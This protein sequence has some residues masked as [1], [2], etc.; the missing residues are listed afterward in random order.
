[1]KLTK[2]KKDII[3]CLILIAITCIIF[4][5]FLQGHYIADTY[6]IIERGLLDYSIGNSFT[7]GRMIMGLLNL[8]IDSL[9]IPMM[10]YV[11]G[12]LFF[13]IILS[14]ITIMVLK[15]TILKFRPA[16]NMWLEILV[17]VI[18]YVTIFNFMYIENLY[19]IECIVMALSLL[20]YTIGANLLVE[21]NKGYLWKSAVCVTVGMLAY[22]GTIGFFLALVFL[23]SAIKNENKISKIIKD[24]LLSVALF[25]L[26]GLIDIVAIKIFTSQLNTEQT[27]LSNSIW[28]NIL[29][30]ITNI[31]KTLTECCGMFPKDSL[32]MFLSI[33]VILAV[34]G[35]VEKYKKDSGKGIIVWFLLVAFVIASGFASSALSTSA[36]WAPRMRFCI[37]ALVGIL[38]L[39]LYVSTDLFQKKNIYTILALIT[40][41]TYTY[42]NMYQYITIINQ[43]K[44]M[45]EVEKQECQ[46]IDE[47]IKEYEQ[48][49][50]IEVTKIAR[51]VTNQHVAGLYYLPGYTKRVNRTVFNSTKC[52]WSAKGVIYFYTN[53]RLEYTNP[54]AD[55]IT[56]LN[57]TG[58]E[59]T[60][61]GDTLYI[62]I[63]QA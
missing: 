41:A 42:L 52:M 61:V 9:N 62:F 27:R 14:C 31:P 38:C 24:V 22:Q 3:I 28:K 53:R 6:S 39:Y 45:N 48:E 30:I 44:P 60:C 23:F 2:N 55:G 10:A 19:F 51:V 13:A 47:Y 11:I 16:E 4:I 20:V 37:G 59:Y 49:N 5:P 40:V 35:M 34:V 50:G 63:Y 12:T 18:C 1:M 26:A 46:E 21:K 36:F 25:V 8:F 54:T 43:N 7:D 58:K 33:L 56:I 29:A 32:I 57:S 17:T 15:N